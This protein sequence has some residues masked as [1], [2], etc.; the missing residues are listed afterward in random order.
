MLWEKLELPTPGWPGGPRWARLRVCQRPPGSP[1]G[2]AP[3]CRIVLTLR[4]LAAV[5]VHEVEVAVVAEAGNVALRLGQH[6]LH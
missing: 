2:S 3:N 1:C 6:H 5:V 4:V